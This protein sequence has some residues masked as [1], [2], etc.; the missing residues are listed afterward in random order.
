M[1]IFGTGGG[2]KLAKVTNVDFLGAI[3]IDPTI[4]EGGDKGKPIVITA[5]D[6]P[7]SQ[8]LS[9]IAAETALRASVIG[10][11]NQSQGI[12]IEIVD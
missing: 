10:L 4:R 11:R 9:R 3:P 1:D 5:P 6:S 8:M 2:K 12:P 7:A